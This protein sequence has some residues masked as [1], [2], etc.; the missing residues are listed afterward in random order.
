MMVY[1]ILTQTNM[2]EIKE[3]RMHLALAVASI[4]F[5]SLDGLNA[6]TIRGIVTEATTGEPIVGATVVLKETTLGT[7]TDLDGKYILTSIPTGRYTVEASFVGFDPM[8]NKEV[9]VAGNREMVLNFALSESSLSLGEVTIRPDVNKEKAV[10][11]MAIVGA[12]MLSMEEAS[13]YAGGYSDPARLVTAFAGVTGSPDNNGISVHGNAPQSL[14]WRLEGIEINSPNHFT[15][16]FNMGTG[17]V[18]ALNSHVLGNS[19]F[20]SGAMTAEYGNALSGVMDMKMRSGNNQTYQHALQ[21]GTLGVEGISEGPISQKTG[22]SY[23]INYRY[24][25]ST[26]A[27]EIGLLTVDGDQADFQDVNFKFN[28]PTRLAGTF[29]VFGLGLKDKYWNDIEAADKRET[30]YDQEYLESR[31]TMFVGGLSHHIYLGKGW[32]WTTTL[33]GSYFKND[34]DD[35]Y[36]DLDF[37]HNFK[38]GEL[39]PYA[40][41]RQKNSQLTAQTALQKRFSH[42]FTSKLGATYSEYYFDIHMTKSEALNKPLP[43]TYLYEADSHTGLLTAYLANSWKWNRFFTFNFGLNLQYFRLNDDKTFEPRAALQW[44]PDAKN[45]FSLGYGLHSKMEKMDVYFVKDPTRHQFVNQDLKL[46]K[47]HHLLA[48]WM[49]RFNDQLNFR[50]EAYYQRLFDLPVAADPTD[51][52]CIINRRD[53]YVDRALNN[54]GKGRNYGIDLTLER[55]MHG[56]WYGMLNGSL[57]KAE[58]QAQDGVWRN[59]RYNRT[60]STKILGG[61]EWLMGRRKQNVLSVNAKFTLQGG[62]R[63]TPADLQATKEEYFSHHLPDVAY[64]DKNAFSQQ[65]APIGVLD[66]TVSYKIAGKHC[67]HT[68]AVEALNLTGVK[69]PYTDTYNYKYDRMDLMYSSLSFPSIYYRISF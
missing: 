15:D 46:S 58:Y 45:T 16:A 28:F 60:F 64:D 69:P 18:S 7:V 17:V 22:S 59:T 51:T 9:L 30:F 13:R 24:S 44:E 23:L 5:I 3:W 41:M 62:M 40:V 4:L 38:A 54:E 31:Q 43:D 66:L 20:Y 47:A 49:Y 1:P 52:Y 42:Q 37:Q 36:F 61:K 6:Q 34:G 67:D 53:Y 68:I 48:S 11:Q 63:Y 55:D 27:R 56:G 14:S 26:L 10:N 33:A 12:R 65:Y 57:Y 32:N 25:F 39:K 2:K 8:A 50:A 29:S 21:L 19:D 35:S